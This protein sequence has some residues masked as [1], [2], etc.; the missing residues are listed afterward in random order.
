MGEKVDKSKQFIYPFS[1]TLA[2]VSFLSHLF[3]PNTSHFI[4]VL[5]QAQK[6][7]FMT[8]IKYRLY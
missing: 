4:S 7:L 6:T 1:V 3:S 2:L 5:F 8:C